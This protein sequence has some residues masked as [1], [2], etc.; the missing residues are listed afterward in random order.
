MLVV[1][2]VNARRRQQPTEGQRPVAAPRLDVPESGQELCDSLLADARASYALRDDDV[3]VC[4]N[5]PLGLV[6][7]AALEM[8]RRLADR[9]LLADPD[10]VFEASA[11]EALAMMSGSGPTAA[12]LAERWDTRA[13]AA[14]DDPPLHLDGGGPRLAPAVLP[15]SVARLS[16]IRNAVWSVAPPRVHAPLHGIGIGSQVAA[17]TARLVRNPEEMF[18]L[19]DG[20]V[21]VAVATTTAFNTVFPLLAAVVTE[22][23][24]LFSH[25]AILSREL[26]LPAVVGVPDLFEGVRDGDVI[27]VDPVAGSVRVVDRAS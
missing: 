20:D 4:W 26:G 6:R 1:A 2:S 19:E 14:V 5:W 9:D 25:T 10:H 11:A 16:E 15:P 13:R 21:L 22:Q 8:G 24:G 23:G 17:G 3:G 27:E 18:L 7:R 12:T